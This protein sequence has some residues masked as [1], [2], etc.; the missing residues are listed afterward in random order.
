MA[1]PVIFRVERSGPFKGVVTA[2]LPTMPATPNQAEFTTFD[3]LGGFSAG[4]VAWYNGTRAATPA[5]A[6]RLLQT[7][8]ELFDGDA[9]VPIKRMSRGHQKIREAELDR[10]FLN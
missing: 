4:G 8:Q 3:L 10:L 5:E 7:L 6:W 9:V 2:V 1:I